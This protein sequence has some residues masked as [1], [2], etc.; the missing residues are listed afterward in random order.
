MI[1]KVKSQA[2]STN[3]SNAQS[4]LNSIKGIKSNK[5]KMPRTKGMK[6]SGTKRKRRM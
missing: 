1:N 6:S 5:R 2:Y 3:S 4:Y